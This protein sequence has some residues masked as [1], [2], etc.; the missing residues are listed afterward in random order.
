MSKKR[1]TARR[2]DDDELIEKITHEFQSRDIS[3]S[4]PNKV[5]N[6]KI[7]SFLSTIMHFASLTPPNDLSMPNIQQNGIDNDNTSHVIIKRCASFTGN[8][9]QFIFS[10]VMA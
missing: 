6:S 5:S 4:E 10:Y 8:S 9:K 1:P 2:V 7:W 3:K